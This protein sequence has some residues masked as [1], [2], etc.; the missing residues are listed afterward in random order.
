MSNF[1]IVN[2]ASQIALSSKWIDSPKFKNKDARVDAQRKAIGADFAGPQFRLIAKKERHF[3]CIERAG[4]GYLGFLAVI[5][6][7]GLALI[8]KS[9]RNLFTKQKAKRFFG[10]AETPAASV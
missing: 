6:S 7:L 10:I 3:S 8:S 2:D 9:V 1:K 5:Y 4:R